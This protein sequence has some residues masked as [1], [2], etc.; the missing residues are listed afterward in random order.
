MD[1]HLAQTNRRAR[2]EALVLARI[3]NAID[4]L[5]DAVRLA[6]SDGVKNYQLVGPDKRKKLSGLI[7]HY[8]KSARPFSDC[9]R[10]NRKRFPG[11]GQAEKVCAV[12]TDLEKGTTK[13]RSGGRRK[14]VAASLPTIDEELGGLLLAISEIPY[15][16]I[17]GLETEEAS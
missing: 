5:C 9:V 12:L 17:I 7:N 2:G 4:K 15:R 16:K 8:R 14:G 1:L 11:A 6:G 3:D 10:D 13:W